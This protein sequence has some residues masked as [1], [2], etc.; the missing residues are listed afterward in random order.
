MNATLLKLL[1]EIRALLDQALV[2]VQASSPAARQAN[3]EEPVR[4]AG[5]ISFEL[6]AHAFMNKHAKGMNGSQKFTLL[7]AWLSKGVVG[8][9]IS[10]DTVGAHWNT[11]RTLLGEFN[12]VHG[13]RA[14]AEGWLD[15]P[16]RGTYVLS[17]FWKG[18][19][20]DQ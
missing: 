20:A 8:T 10:T 5:Q 6:N 1:Q 12:R 7:V 18:C 2:E 9:E 4:H 17:D 14:K 15:S 3:R 16:K 11:M 19:L 13:T